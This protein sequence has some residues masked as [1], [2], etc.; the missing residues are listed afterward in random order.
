VISETTPFELL[1]CSWPFPFSPEDFKPEWHA[2]LTH[3]RPSP[4][5]KPSGDRLYW[6]ID[7]GETFRGGARFLGTMRQFGVV[8][9]IRVNAAGKL[10]F[11]S[12]GCCAIKRGELRVFEGASEPEASIEVSAGDIL[13]I[14]VAHGPDEWNWGARIEPVANPGW[15]LRSIHLPRV[16]ARLREPN[17]P[18]LKIFTDARHPMRTVIAI[19]SMILNGY[20]PSKVYLYGDYQWTPF[21][22]AV[23][24]PFL[25]FA[26]VVPL[27][28]IRDQIA[29]VAPLQLADLAKDNWLVMKCCLTLLCDPLEFCMVDDDLFILKSVAHPLELFQKTDFVFVPEIDNSMHYRRIWSDL[30]PEVTPTRTARLNGALCWLRMRKD[31]KTTADLMMRGLGKLDGLPKVEAA[32]SWEQGFYAYL[33][34]NDSIVELP[35]ELYWYP[36]FCG[37]PGGILGYDYANNPCGFTTVHFGGDVPKPTDSEALLL[38]PQIL[39]R[40]PQA[41]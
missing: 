33:F 21:A 5:W 29:Q 24:A 26:T 36:F 1:S 34:A 41:R 20:S 31:R 14:A 28:D 22:K 39:G 10:A 7:W 37:L 35:A 3:L 30:F 25:P 38:M 6:S 16:Q 15:E 12:L 13:D 8:F 4:E 9:R 2:P 18:P 19:Y 32:W 17:G 11:R 27:Q 40:D 23:L